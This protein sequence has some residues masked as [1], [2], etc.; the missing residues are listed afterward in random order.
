MIVVPRVL[1][2]VYNAASQKAGH[3][4]KG[5]ALA[6]R[7]G[8][9]PGRNY[10]KEVSANGK[11]G[12]L[13]PH[14]PRCLRSDC[15]LFAARKCSGWS[16][17]VDC[18]RRCPCLTRNCW[19]S[20]AVRG[21]AGILEGYGLTADHR[22]VRVQPAGQER[23][24]TRVP[25]ASHSPHSLLRIAEDGEI[26]AKGRAAFPRYQQRTNEATEPSFTEGLAG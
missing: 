18:G 20:S 4:P 17:Q 25:W 3:G 19:L 15:L 6:L 22:T 10:M 16:R 11:A 7:R 23:R 26:Q 1:E 21:R 9:P 8:G 2:K 12:A 24:S 13:T 5:A 14:S